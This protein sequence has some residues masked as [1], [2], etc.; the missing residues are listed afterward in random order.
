RA[1][2][3]LA[4][5][6]LRR[7]L[8]GATRSRHWALAPVAIY[9]ATIAAWDSKYAYQRPRPSV[10]DPT[11][12]TVV[13][14]PRSPSYPSEHAAVAAAAAGVL[15]YLFADDAQ[16]FMDMASEAASSRELAG[17]KYPSDTAVGLKQG[18]QM[19]D[20]VIE[21]AQRD[22]SATWDGVLPTE[23]GKWNLTG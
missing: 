9:D 6:L 21:R 8:L 22:F 5:E 16:A 23:P 1:T 14:T 20:L 12:Q 19:A 11:L 18:R 13:E 7:N 2:A 10:L 3:I 17:G 4:D 15:G